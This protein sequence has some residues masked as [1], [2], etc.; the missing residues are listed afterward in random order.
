MRAFNFK[1]VDEHGVAEYHKPTILMTFIVAV[2]LIVWSMGLLLFHFESGVE[3]ANILSRQDA[4]W[5]IWMSASTIGF[6]DF[7]PV[8]LGGRIVVGSMFVVG[9]INIGFVVGFVSDYLRDLFDKS[10]QNRELKSQL[11]VVLQK[12]DRLEDQL[13]IDQRVA[14]GSDAHGIDHVISQHGNEQRNR[15]LTLGRDDSG[16]YVVTDNRQTESGNTLNWKTFTRKEDALAYFQHQ[17][18]SSACQLVLR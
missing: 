8:T 4:W 1:T 10:I 15:L 13:N 11:S 3:T 9:A 7:Y 16:H 5:T 18:K 6:G 14:F 2:A 17:S 12:L